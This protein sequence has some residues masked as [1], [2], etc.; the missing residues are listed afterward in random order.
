M[1][2]EKYISIYDGWFHHK[3]RIAIN[4]RIELNTTLP[5]SFLSSVDF[6]FPLSKSYGKNNNDALIGKLFLLS[7]I[8]VNVLQ[9]TSLL[10]SHFQHMMDSFW[11]PEV[12]FFLL[13]PF[14]IIKI[15]LMLNF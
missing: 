5:A 8:Y 13:F 15:H 4:F 2:S 11:T 14:L 3:K 1:V 10:H 7:K 6:W 9:S 12:L